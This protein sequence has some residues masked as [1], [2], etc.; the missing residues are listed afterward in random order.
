MLLLLVLEV[1]F[2]LLLRKLLL[3][4]N[5]LTTW[6]LVK[7]AL[8]LILNFHVS[9]KRVIQSVYSRS[10]IINL[11]RLGLRLNTTHETRFHLF[12]LNCFNKSRFIHIDAMFHLQFLCITDQKAFIPC[13]FISHWL[14]G[15]FVNSHV[16]LHG[17]HCHEKL[18]SDIKNI[19]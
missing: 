10:I 16:D 8:H 9:L 7:P 17:V 14:N 6:A 15:D 5:V 11:V 13:Q 18:F 3:L 19:S 4:L 1:L 12:L 2:K